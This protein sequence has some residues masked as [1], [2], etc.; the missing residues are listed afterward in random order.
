MKICVTGGAGFIGS[1]L[2][3]KI[4]EQSDHSILNIDNL[5][6]SGEMNPFNSNVSK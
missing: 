4:L 1:A 2:I 6:T 3:K 5:S